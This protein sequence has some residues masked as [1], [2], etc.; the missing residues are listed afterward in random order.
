MAKFFPLLLLM[1]LLPV[2][3]AAQDKISTI[4]SVKKT[5]TIVKINDGDAPKIDGDLT[6]GVWNLTKEYGDFTLLE[7]NPGGQPSQPTY[8]KLL[9]DNTAFYVYAKMVDNPENIL[10][11]L[12][13]RDNY[14]NTDFIGIIFDPYAA[15]TNGFGFYVSPR[16]LQL[17]AR[18]VSL[19]EDDSWDGIWESAAKEVNDGWQI[20]MRIPFSQLRFPK[21]DIQNWN[22]NLVRQMKK[23]REK[24][25]WVKVDPTISGFLNQSGHLEGLK[26]I[27]SP[28]R[29]S[30]FP[31]VSAYY[32][33]ESNKEF[34]ISG[35][36]DLK[37]GINDAFTLDL[38]LIPDFGQVSFDEQVNNLGPFEVFFEER[39]PFFTEG[40]ELFSRAELFYSRRIAGDN[41]YF[42][43]YGVPEGK[44][45]QDYPTKNKLLNAFKLTGRDKDGLGVG[46]FNAIEGR[47]YATL[48][49]NETGE[50][51]KLL[52]NSVSNFNMIVLDKNLKNNSYISFI[53]TNVIRQGEF[54]D[55]N[56]SGID[57]DIRNKKQNYFVKGN[58]SFSYISEKEIAKP[59]YKYVIDVG[60]NSGNFTYD[61]L[62]Q[63]ISK[64][65][66]PT[67]MGFL[68]IFNNRSTIL[69]I[70]YST[71][72]QSK[73]R[74]KSTSSFSVQYDRQLKP[75]VFANFALETGHFYLDRNFNAAQVTIRA[76]PV[77]TYDYYE[78]RRSDFSRYYTYPTNIMVRSFISSDYRK[79]F[80]LDASY[81]YRQWNE[82]G[83]LQ[84]NMDLSPR[85][86]FN[87]HFSIFG[88]VGFNKLLN[89]VG[90]AYTNQLDNEFFD[91]GDI[92]FSVRDIK[93]IELG[94]NPIILINPNRNFSLRIRNY[95]SQVKF[96]KYEK[97]GL[98]GYLVPNLLEPTGNNKFSVVEFTNFEARANWRF[99]PGSD[100]VLAW[101]SG[102]S[103]F[104]DN[105][106][107]YWK[108]YNG[109][110]NK[111]KGNSISIRFNYFLDY[112][113]FVKHHKS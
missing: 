79:P 72:V 49:D 13:Q 109:F 10:K 50:T 80:A 4:D 100:I 46:V 24:G 82:D 48:K 11:E 74:N 69:N 68:G 111:I 66:D 101:N 43:K 22:I 97:L 53:N 112:A 86:R 31:Y 36:L 89:D 19:D 75:D 71:Y 26:N 59:G 44:S 90:Y 15:G 64:R 110:L 52:I 85:I 55:A 12:A 65:Y 91:Q 56:V 54:R 6:D 37:Y 99:A 95:W 93:T 17:D 61:L 104:S 18:Y 76:E 58:G 81:N 60:K 20:E 40:L 62:Y 107:R 34:K 41:N 113:Q 84:H 7:P 70:A 1:L 73:Y 98:D 47:S 5:C 30:L 92:I 102:N 25:T 78:P 9:Y 96:D 77:I 27:Q 103:D 35:G 14:N 57:F 3:C 108:S 39:R 21:Q 16:N 106:N 2:F 28:L 94:L 51:E 32:A 8:F 63:E 105:S 23:S 87:D 38:T 42:N 83:R 33:P 45:I 67:D 88:T 29:L